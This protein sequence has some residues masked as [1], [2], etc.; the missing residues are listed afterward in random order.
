M[1]QLARATVDVAPDPAVK[2]R[3]RAISPRRLHGAAPRRTWHLGE[4]RQQN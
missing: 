1:D 2:R 3:Q 4:H